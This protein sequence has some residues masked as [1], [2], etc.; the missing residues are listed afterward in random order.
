MLYLLP[1]A[2]V[3]VSE[4]LDLVLSFKESSREV[5]FFATAD[6]YHVLHVAEFDNLLLKFLSVDSQLFCLSVQ[7]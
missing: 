7:L 6:G 1:E 3:L 4:E 2:L 5:V